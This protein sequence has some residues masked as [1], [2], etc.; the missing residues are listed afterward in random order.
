[1][2]NGQPFSTCGTYIRWSTFRSYRIVS[3]Y[4]VWYRIV[5]CPLWLYR[6][7]TTT[8]NTNVVVSHWSI[9]RNRNQFQI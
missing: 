2:V 7:I 4:F 6:A 5:S 9:C 1:V 8:Y 3:R